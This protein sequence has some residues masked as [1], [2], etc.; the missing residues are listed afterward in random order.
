MLLQN[1]KNDM[2]K[3]V[4]SNKKEDVKVMKKYFLVTAALATTLLLGACS[5]KDE[6]GMKL[7]NGNDNFI[8]SDVANITK[9]QVFDE[10]VTDAGLSALLDLVDYDV[11]ST[12]YEIDTAKVDSAI[13]MYKQMY[14]E[15]ED[16][17]LAQGFKNEEALRQYLE[18]NLYREAAA[19]AAVTVTDEEIQ[20][21]YDEKY[22]KDE[23]AEST[24]ES[25][26]TNSEETKEI[27]TL[28]E[29]KDELTETL[30]Q[31]KLT[32]EF[33]VATL[34]TEREAD[35]FV[36]TNDFLET[37]YKEI[38]TTYEES[39]ETNSSII[40]KITD[41]EY[42]VEQLYDELVPAYGL[43]D[44]ISLVDEQILEK[45]YPVDKKEV[46]ELIDQFKVAYGTNYYQA[47]ESAG[48]KT[49]EEIYNYFKLAQLQ[50]AA[51]AEAYPITDEMLQKLY[52]ETLPKI[53]ARHILVADEETAKEI[54]AKLDAAEDKE[55]TFKE[56]AGEYGT[57]GTKEN[58]G[59]LGTFGQ[60]EMVAEFENA[61]Y[62]LEVGHYS[63]EPVKTKFGYH[64]I[65]K[66]AENEKASFE[67]MKEELEQTAKKQEYTQ[68]RLETLL[69]KF[70]SEANF[71]FT[72]EFLQKRYETIVA[73]I[74]ES[75]AQEE[76][77]K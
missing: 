74:E 64:V 68:L 30:I 5:N 39:K 52:D 71:K 56:L 58:G 66:Y 15:F 50:D 9:Q 19:R 14:P 65:Y 63:T 29:V 7:P 45:K 46:K 53:S 21:A 2:I 36:L 69:I 73:N 13:D 12:K 8:T 40:A 62:A 41:H 57:D 32:D 20:T 25:E 54:I 43:S 34:A 60:G 72:D 75:A 28:E 16:F 61:A 27:P 44:G 37:Q 70:R 31:N 17:L 23:E 10:M 76:T 59:D 49:D 6:I 26:S 47:M 38:S 55:A 24:E 11:L 22:K 67:D 48:L 51:L 3:N 77:A 18:L 33:I 42:T 1:L 35:G 4:K